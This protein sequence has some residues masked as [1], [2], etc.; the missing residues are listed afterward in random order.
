MCRMPALA[1]TLLALAAAPALAAAA[2]PVAGAQPATAPAQRAKA[3]AEMRA[4]ARRVDPLAR[5]AFWARELDIDNRDQ[6]AGVGLAQAL[7]QL[8]RYDEAADAA[9]KVLVIAPD[10]V[11]ALLEVAR[12]QIARGQGFYAIEPAK[13][14][15]ALAPRDWRPASLLAV[16]LE[17]AGRDSEALAAH[18][19]AL[20]LAPSE[21]G[22]LSNF[23]M[24]KATHGD[25]PGAEKMLR[26]AAASPRAD[27]R[28]RQNLALVIGLQ[29]RLAEAE[30][31]VRQDL[32]PEQAA[33]NL[34]WLKAATQRPATPASAPT[35]SWDAVRGGGS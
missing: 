25:L 26:A 21:P 23:A 6:E 12:A 2:A 15:Q 27:A 18:Q 7:R 14:A 34:A 32:P 20:A 31:L 29:G 8:G 5:A 13:R 9:G 10:N 33:S 35:R 30:P 19:Q 22:V 17:Q 1:A 24:F 4:E 16:G 3:S 11:D 28:V